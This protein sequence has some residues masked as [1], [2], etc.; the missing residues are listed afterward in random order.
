MLANLSVFRSTCDRQISDEPG[1]SV[2]VV[3]TSVDN[4]FLARLSKVNFANP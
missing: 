4:E 2:L 1:A 3:Y